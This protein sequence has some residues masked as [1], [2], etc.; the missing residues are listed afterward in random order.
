MAS[1]SRHEMQS[2]SGFGPDD[3]SV[4]NFSNP[5]YGHGEN[6]FSHPGESHTNYGEDEFSATFAMFRFKVEKCSKQFVH[7]WKE[8]PYAHEGETARRRHPSTHSAQPCPDFKNS[9]SCTRYKFYLT[10][11]CCTC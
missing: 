11:I 3:Y 4:S 2:V 1:M 10:Q 6:I 5:H 9:K 7:D 8:C